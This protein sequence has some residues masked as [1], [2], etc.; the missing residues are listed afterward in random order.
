MRRVL[1]VAPMNVQSGRAHVHNVLK[2]V[3]SM[4]DAGA[5]MHLVL[6]DVRSVDWAG[7]CRAHHIDRPPHMSVIGWIPFSWQVS[8]NRLLRGLSIFWIQLAILGF[9]L[10]HLRSF[11]VLYIRHHRLFVVAWIARLFGKKTVY[12]SHYVYIH[13]RVEQWLTERAVRGANGVVYITQALQDFYQTP[14][15]TSCVSRSH[16]AEPWLFPTASQRELRDQL[17]LPQN[18]N[19]LVYTGSVGATIQGISYEV[20]TLIDV[21]VD[22]PATVHSV[23]VGVRSDDRAG[24][25]LRARAER[26]GVLDRVHLVPWC[27]RAD[28]YRYLFAGDVLLLP[29][30]GTAPGSFPSKLYDYLGVGKPIVAAKTPTVNEVLTHEHNALLVD[31]DH[32]AEWLMAINRLLGDSALGARLAQAAEQDAQTHSWEA[33]GKSLLAFIDRLYEAAS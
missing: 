32:S 26:V 9:V 23:I 24:D 29:R 13:D 20:E 5:G 10:A 16:A 18:A 12:E 1:Y 28:T 3:E 33:R 15:V 30:V 21:L 14:V 25:E 27:S 6:T 7:V 19:L 11:D 8:P 17:H 2:T 4:R 22:L 31:A